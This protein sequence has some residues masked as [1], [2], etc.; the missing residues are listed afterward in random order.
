MRFPMQL[1]VSLTKYIMGMKMRGV[2]RYP[3]VLMLEPLHLCNLACMGCGRIREYKDTLQQ[4]MTLSQCV[5][6]VK[7]CGAPVISI[8]GGEPL[9]Y[10]EIGE[11][12]KEVLAL[13]RHIHL[14][15][16]ALKLSE[17]L[18]KFT[19]TPY[20][21]FVVSIDGLE[22]TQEVTR[23]RK[24]IYDVQ[25]KA[26][27]DAKARGFRVITNTTLYK[28]T[29]VLEVEELFDRLTAMNV[30]GLLVTPGYSYGVVKEDIFLDRDASREK[31]R[32]ILKLTKKYRFFNTPLYMRFLAGERDLKCT[33]WG[34]VTV[35]PQGWKAPCYVITDTHYGTY[36]EL[37]ENTDWEKFV[38]RADP[39]C[40]DCMIHSGA[41]PS[42]VEEVGKSLGDL[43]EMVR[44]NF[45]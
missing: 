19:P 12:V 16:N 28:E 32:H 4:M 10:P 24:G 9:I 29:D 42:A 15:T 21:N 31:F 39:R 6:A 14:C 43:I 2:K 1:N 23:G 5:D 11:L 26:I 38:E 40:K 20:L 3:L 7:E 37:M 41:E 30:D 45:S 35:N 25:V 13:D 44:W 18:N 27:R 8:C 34:N 17:S 33:P 22:K 36:R